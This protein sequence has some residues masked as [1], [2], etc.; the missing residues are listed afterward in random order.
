M[1]VRMQFQDLTEEEHSMIRGFLEWLC[2]KIFIFMNREANRKRI[3][4]RLD[5]IKKV[6]WIQWVDSKDITVNEILSA[7]RKSLKIRK[8]KL[9]WYI[10]ID[11]RVMIPHTITPISKLIRF[12]D[13]GDGIVAGTGMIQFIKR[14]FN[15]IQLNKWW[16]GYVMLKSNVY[17]RGKVISD[18]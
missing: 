5:Y 6:K 12:I 18:R 2:D 8:K 15:A 14:Q 1:I 7:I 13:H 9:T 11:N 17:S 3:Q 4:I 16:I 10:E